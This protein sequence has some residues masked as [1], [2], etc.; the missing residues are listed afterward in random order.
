MLAAIQGLVRLLFVTGLTTGVFKFI[1]T[2]FIFLSLEYFL[3]NITGVVPPFFS[4]TYLQQMW[5]LSFNSAHSIF[6]AQT[7]GYNGW[8]LFGYYLDMFAVFFTVGTM[9][10]ADITRFLIRRI[11]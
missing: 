7:Q 3:A 4:S 9:I 5:D 2:A 8:A 6:S 11:F 10:N 1:S